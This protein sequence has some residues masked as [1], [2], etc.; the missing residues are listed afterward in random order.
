[1]RLR[2]SNSS[3]KDFTRERERMVERDLVGRSIRDPRVLEAMRQVPREVFVPEDVREAAYEDG[4][5]PIG[6]GQTISQ[7]FTVALMLQAAEVSPEDRV[8][9]VGTGSGYAAA[10]ARLLAAHVYSIERHLPLLETA[11]RCFDE[12]GYRN[13][14]TL[15]GDGTLGWPEAAPFDAILVAAGGPEIPQALS[16][17][18]SI[19]GRLVMPVGPKSDQRLLRVRRCGEYDFVNDDLGSVSFVPLI[20]KQG[21]SPGKQ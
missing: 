1:M 19:G 13:I 9:D 6:E 3:K 18:L 20:G 10:V 7:P 11:C 14:T 16:N 15:H 21:W 4:P 8:L 2:R 5:L 12:L 17:Q